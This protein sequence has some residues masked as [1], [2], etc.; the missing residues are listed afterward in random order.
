MESLRPSDAASTVRLR[1]CDAVSGQL[2]VTVTSN[3]WVSSVSGVP[4][5][6]PLFGFRDSWFGRSP[7]VSAKA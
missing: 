6:R 7:S 5:I 3:A 2:S 1:A 4:V